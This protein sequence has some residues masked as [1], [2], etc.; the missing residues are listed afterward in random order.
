MSFQVNINANTVPSTDMY[1]IDEQRLSNAIA[2]KDWEECWECICLTFRNL[3]EDKRIPMQM[4]VDFRTPEGIQRNHAYAQMISK[5]MLT[6]LLNEEVTMS[7]EKFYRLLYYHEMIH[8]FF[9]V[10]SLDE[11]DAQVTEFMERHPKPNR[12]QQKKLGVLL[13]LNSSLDILDIMKP[14]HT[15]YRGALLLAHCGS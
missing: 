11:T 15:K 10:V 7:D 13:S 2:M 3:T 14:M 6:L 9:C 5:I 1:Q 8:N 4:M 12:D